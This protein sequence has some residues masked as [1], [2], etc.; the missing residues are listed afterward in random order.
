MADSQNALRLYPTPWKGE[1]VFACRKCQ[2]RMKKSGGPDALR[3]LKKWFRK[4]AR[5]TPEAPAV[6]VI[7]ISCLKLCPKGGVT[8]FSG[9]QLGRELGISIARSEEDLEKLYCELT[10][11]ALSPE[12]STLT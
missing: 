6:S 9:R 12:K 2:R 7:E 10:D 11:V 8:V 5:S 1:A 3:K 4:R